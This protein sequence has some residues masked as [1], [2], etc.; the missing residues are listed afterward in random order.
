MQGV[1]SWMYGEFVGGRGAVG[2]LL[3]RVF[4]GVALMM[5][6]WPKIQAPFSWT[7]GIPGPLQ[8]AAA[9]S[10][11]G[12]GLALALGFLTPLAAFGIACTMGVAAMMA[13]GS[14]PF[15]A[16]N[17]KGLPHVASK[18]PALTYLA[19]A[20]L[21]MLIGPGRISLDWLLFGSRRG[22]YGGRSKR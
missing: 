12:G 9:L 15:M 8:A 19:M 11:F 16:S 5:H 1:L 10:E 3:L 4:A 17:R 13:H 21:L 7:K 18:E 22:S 6:G 14:D 20:L 2:L